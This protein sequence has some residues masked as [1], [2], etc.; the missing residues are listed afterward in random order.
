MTAGWADGKHTQEDPDLESL[1]ELPTFQTLVKKMEEKEREPLD[2]QPTTAFRSKYLWD[3]TGARVSERGVRY[4]LSTML[5]VTSGRGN[6]VREA[7]DYL[8]R[9]VAAD[10]THPRGTI[11]FMEN[12]DV[13]SATR[14]WAFASTVKALEGTGVQGAIV[15][16]SLPQKKDDVLG[17]M[18]GSAG[19]DWKNSGSTILPGDGFPAGSGFAPGPIGMTDNPCWPRPPV[20]LVWVSPPMMPDCCCSSR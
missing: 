6:S 17:A 19:V 4:V 10:A 16:G 3:P 5:A 18:I 11:Y 7:L 14:Q 12:T 13:R 20:V 9:S 2:V 15:K 8:Q 1:R